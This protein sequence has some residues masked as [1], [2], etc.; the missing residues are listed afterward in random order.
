[1]TD[2]TDTVVSDLNIKEISSISSLSIAPELSESVSFSIDA[3]IF[4][5]RMYLNS[6][7]LIFSLEESFDADESG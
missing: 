1:M 2:P 7:L 3:L 4:V 5:T 6:T